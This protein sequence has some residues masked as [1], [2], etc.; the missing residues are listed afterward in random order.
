MTLC[1]KT[2]ITALIILY[3]VTLADIPD[4]PYFGQEPPGSKPVVFAPGIISLEN[5]QECGLTFSP[6]C[7]ECIFQTL[8]GETFYTKQVDGKWTEPVLA[9][10]FGDME[11]VSNPVFSP[12]GKKI[13]FMH[14]AKG[15]ST[16]EGEIW[17]CDRT[18]QGWSVPHKM[19]EPP[20]SSKSTFIHSI[21]LNGNIYF[22]R[23]RSDIKHFDLYCSKYINNQYTPAENLAALSSLHHEFSV[24][25]APD[26]SYVLFSSYKRDDGFGSNDL[27]IGFRN[28]DGTWQKPANLGHGINTENNEI[29]GF[30][31]PDGKYIIF[32]RSIGGKWDLY[33]VDAQ[34]ILPDPKGPVRN[35]NAGQ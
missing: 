5:R 3:S 11:H 24:F 22:S 7:R 6:D 32:T 2:T 30:V 13:S 34:S 15:I 23:Y 14:N 29:G 21:A 4:G 19:P 26:E 20:N 16:G 35:L 27:Y 28:E 12:D 10:F 25:I 33:W 9:N 17:F 8:V 31:T 1:Y 18:D